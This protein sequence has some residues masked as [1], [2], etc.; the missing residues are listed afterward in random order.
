MFFLLALHWAG[1]LDR[2]DE[3]SVAAIQ[4]ARGH[5]Y[6]VPQIELRSGAQLPN[7]FY[8]L[9]SDSMESPAT[10]PLRLFEDARLI[11][12][13][14]ALHREIEEVGGGLYSHWNGALWFSTSD[15]SD[16]RRNGR[17]YTATLS[18]S[19]ARL[20]LVPGVLLIGLLG[21]RQSR[22]VAAGLPEIRA[23]AAGLRR[24]R[25]LARHR[26]AIR[27]AIDSGVF[28]LLVSLIL[29][30][31]L[32]LAT[33]DLGGPPSADGG[34]LFEFVKFVRTAA[35]GLVFWNSFR[36]GGYPLFADPE[37]AWLLSLFVSP[38]GPT[39]YVEF[40]VAF[41]AVLAALAV[42]I[43]LVCRRLDFSP[44]WTVIL[45][46]TLGFNEGLIWAQQSG[47]FGFVVMASVLLTIVWVLLSERLRPRHYVLLAVCIAVA[48]EEGA[49]KAVLHCLVLYAGLLLRQGLPLK[50]PWRQVLHATAAT[51]AISLVGLCLSAV[52]MLP[53]FAW[54]SHSHTPISALTYAANVP[55]NVLDYA[56]TIVPFAPAKGELV[57]FTS[58]LLFPAALLF[59]S[60]RPA[61]P[62]TR[63]VAIGIPVYLWALIFISMSLPFAGPLIQT[64][65]AAFPPIAGLRWFTRF[66]F[67]SMMFLS[68]G[69][70]G[71]FQSCESRRI[72][73]I[74]RKTRVLIG[75]YFSAC[76][77]FALWHGVQHDEALAIYAGTAIASFALYFLATATG[78]LAIGRLE[79]MTIKSSVAVLAAISAVTTMAAG[80]HWA[81]ELPRRDPHQFT[82]LQNIVRNDPDAYFRHVRVI[83]SDLWPLE[84]QKRGLRAFSL[85]FSN[86]FARSLLYLNPRHD[87]VEL[88]PHWVSLADCD[89]LD[90]RALDLL[91]TKYVFCQRAALP[92]SDWEPVAGEQGQTLFR[93]R[94]YDGGIR[95][96]CRWRAVG[97]E[98]D[99]PARD[100]V[101]EAFSQRVALVSPEDAA[102]M[103]VAD[104][105]CPAQGQAIAK[106]DMVEDR[107][108]RM[109]LNVTARNG[110]V[111]VIPDNYAPG[112]RASINGRTA[113]ALRVYR[114]YLG[115]GI[116]RGE[117]SITF[118]FV[119]DWFWIGLTISLIT[120]T[121]LMVYSAISFAAGRVKQNKWWARPTLR[122]LQP[123]S[124][125]TD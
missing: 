48:I 8:D 35:H 34:R 116:E 61:V 13:P 123:T 98:L 124:R 62:V 28:A 121:G 37:H 38:V 75:S 59:A 15:N 77:G 11:D 125:D 7:W 40:N 73:E 17:R 84:A 52:W 26:S 74:G 58:L 44:F 106:I 87:L 3:I 60:A 50:Q 42:P 5:A 101:L 114:A 70:V 117:N 29:V 110:G 30:V 115:V 103:P 68:I 43:W 10:S 67:A 49:Q 4:P 32:W 89:G 57:V 1:A 81:R 88:R 85:Y 104:P 97:E 82:T 14:H 21:W 76:A 47:R 93:R 53:L 120:L 18:P 80:L 92:T 118:E 90:P 45:I 72:A 78:R 46:V 99:S 51:V 69:A 39:G 2:V 64:A 107:P 109:V 20:F 63:A 94:D 19:P 41:L 12:R 122:S 79:H 83:S 23:G 33:M 102:A 91:G 54:F 111:L 55:D 100:A 95:L 86:E 22:G 36:N 24:M 31:A 6:V 56:R 112:W 27:F 9:R 16:P 66:N 71:M 119:D 65:Y 113:R 105:D 108:G 96:Y 25:Q